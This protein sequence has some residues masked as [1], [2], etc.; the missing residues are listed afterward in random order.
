MTI[1]HYSPERKES[2]LRK[3][4]PPNNISIAKLSLDMGVSQATLYYWRKQPNN[5]SQVMP[6]K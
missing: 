2:S 4:R 3:M 6:G 5:K 1:Q